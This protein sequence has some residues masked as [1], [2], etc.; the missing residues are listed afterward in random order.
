[1]CG[2]EFLGSARFD[3]LSAV[4]VKALSLLK[5]ERKLSAIRMILEEVK[6]SDFPDD[7]QDEVK[8]ITTIAQGALRGAHKH[9]RRKSTVI[10]KSPKRSRPRQP[11]R[12]KTCVT[13]QTSSADASISDIFPYLT[14]DDEQY[15]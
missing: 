1:M 7:M 12:L 15:N 3:K 9:A 5:E 14:S 8:E 4:L 13:S 11:E 10:D 2:K 6:L